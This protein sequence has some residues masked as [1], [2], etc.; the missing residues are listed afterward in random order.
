M[1]SAFI[2]QEKIDSKDALLFSNDIIS[3]FDTLLSAG[4]TS[5]LLGTVEGVY[6]CVPG[7]YLS[8]DTVIA[9]DYVHDNDASPMN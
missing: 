4:G 3:Y 8:A 5:S 2:F 6:G 9:T 7:S 1:V